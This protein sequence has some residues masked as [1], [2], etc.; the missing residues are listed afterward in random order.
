METLCR[1]FMIDEKHFTRALDNDGSFRE[2]DYYL[3]PPSSG[4][5]RCEVKLMGK[6]NPE[7]ADVTLARDSKV[8]VA[9]TMSDTNKTQMN[10]RGVLWTE[11]QTQNG[12][13]RFGETL[14]ELGIPYTELPNKDD[15]ALEIEQVIEGTFVAE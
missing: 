11:L 10:E 15:Y 6:G 8:L 1:L 2:V 14:K 13:L 4:E 9:S 12:F 7:S 5:V 3:L